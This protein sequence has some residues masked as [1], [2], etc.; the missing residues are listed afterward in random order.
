M[1]IK[2][3]VKIGEE[4]DKLSEESLFDN[5]LREEYSQFTQEVDRNWDTAKKCVLS[6]ITEKEFSRYINMICEHAVSRL[7]SKGNAELVFPLQNNT[8]REYTDTVVLAVIGGLI[9]DEIL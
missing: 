4:M 2:S 3:V 5:S 1:S 7:M 6:R 8:L 9:E